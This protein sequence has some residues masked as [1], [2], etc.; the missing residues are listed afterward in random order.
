MPKSTSPDV[1]EVLKTQHEKVKNLLAEVATSEGEAREA[2]FCELR[3]MIAVHETA[4]EEIIY[5]AL[6]STGQEGKQVAEARTSEEAEGTEVLARLENMSP[7]GA[8]FSELFGQFRTAVLNHAEAEETQVI[9]ILQRTQKPEALRKMAKA[10]AVAEKA[11]PTHPHPHA[12]T[13]AANII[14]GPAVAIMDHVR[15]A[16]HKV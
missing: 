11:A 8:E 2:T 7:A 14:A 1:V 12:G 15:D 16:L 3:R 9:P 4:E 10:F 13:G 5:P 6:R